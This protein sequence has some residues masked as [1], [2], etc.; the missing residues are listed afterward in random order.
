MKKFGYYAIWWYMSLA[1]TICCFYWFNR[2]IRFFLLHFLTT[3]YI[4]LRDK[5]PFFSC[6]ER[7]L[8]TF[9]FY[10]ILFYFFQEDDEDECE[11]IKKNTNKRIIHFVRFFLCACMSKGRSVDW[12]LLLKFWFWSFHILYIRIS[13]HFYLHFTIFLPF[14]SCWYYII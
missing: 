10:S 13:F 6:F 7:V 5:L 1:Q 9:V 8:T 3:S 2:Y 4:L 11:W 14:F 12:L